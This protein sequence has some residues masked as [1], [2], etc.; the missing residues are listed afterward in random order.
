MIS[1]EI[2]KDQIKPT[3]SE[4]FF[5]WVIFFGCVF[6]LYFGCQL[7]HLRGRETFIRL[8][9]EETAD[10]VPGVLAHSTVLGN[11]KVSGLKHQNN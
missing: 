3:L 6:G 8:R 5:R 7:W 11:S 10:E 9:D 2:R 4:F 1:F